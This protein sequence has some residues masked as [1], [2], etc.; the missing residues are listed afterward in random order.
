MDNRIY[1]C[2]DLKSFYASVECVERNLD[3]LVTNL[4]V[5]DSSRTEKTICLAIS[6]ALKSFGLPGRA[7]LFE[8]NQKVKEIN[9]IRKYNTKNKK[10]VGKSYNLNELNSNKALEVDFLIAPP[11]M[12][13]YI[14]V[15][16]KIYDV[17]LKYISKEDIHVYSI[18]EVFMDITKY[19][20]LNNVTPFE[21]AKMIIKDVLDTTGI[22]ATAGIGT[23]MYLAK[24]AMDIV[25]KHIEADSDGVRIAYLDEMS[26]RHKLWNHTPLTDFWRVGRGYVK[27][28]ENLGLFTMGDIARC[29]LGKATSYHNEDLLYKEFGV[30]AELLIDHAWGYEPTTIQDIKNYKPKM[31][32]L[33]SGQVLHEG[34]KSDK[35]KIVVKEMMD[36][37]ALDLVNKG[38]VTNYISLSIGY[39]IDNLKN[40]EIMKEYQGDVVLDYMGRNV[41]KG[42]HGSIRL[43]SFTYSS[44]ELKESISKLYDKIINP[45]LLVR[46]LNI[47]VNVVSEKILELE[48]QVEQL[49]LFDSIENKKELEQKRKKELEKDY[50]LQKSLLEIKKKFG[51]N[52]VLKGMDYEEGATQK[53]RNEQIGGHKA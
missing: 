36:S 41:P 9:N 8:V 32:S 12:A 18:D 37:L 15:S 17:Y 20:K 38:L 7:R 35:A 49:S 16:S 3:P 28:L 47:G 27:R 34:Y 43:E 42:S 19:L 30:N 26:Y 5:A 52:S 45:L 33:S 50:K 48:N 40:D 21:L 46:R 29:S 2:I 10:L 24:V 6:P 53:D 14:E 25:A 44:K 22:T 13:H 51:K 23:N 31:N 4:V 1:L 11:Q 39:D